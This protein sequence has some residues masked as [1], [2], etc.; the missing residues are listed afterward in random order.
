M[1]R[2]K[3]ARTAA[4]ALTAAMLGCGRYGFDLEPLLV[5]AGSAGSQQDASGQA[6]MDVGAADA[7]AEGDGSPVDAAE[8]APADQDAAQPCDATR[9]V[10][11]PVTADTY[12]DSANPTFNYGAAV[13][14][15]VT[16]L[17]GALLR[18]DS[19]RIPAQT[20]HSATISVF[21]TQTDAPAGTFGLTV[22]QIASTNSAWGEGTGNGTVGGVGESTYANLDQ[23]GAIPWTGPWGA[24]CGSNC[25]AILATTNVTAPVSRQRIDFVVPVTIVNGW[26][27]APVSNTGVVVN[28][29]VGSHWH[30]VSREGA[31]QSERP[32]LRVEVDCP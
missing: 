28:E 8:D 27:N 6:G 3:K 16:Q 7:V 1:S 29:H 18:F 21:L 10:S 17:G 12:L 19:S 22:N 11:V 25:A 2:S 5:D 4:L 9:F 23:G 13:D 30:F 32:E 15:D 31:D 24:S 14:L 26:R 20:I